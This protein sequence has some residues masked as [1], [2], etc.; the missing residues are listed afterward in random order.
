MNLADDPRWLLDE[1]PS[2]AWF[3]AALGLTWTHD[4]FD[5]LLVAHSHYR[6]WRLATGDG[7][8]IARLGASATLEL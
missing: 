6:G 5:R 1:P 7:D 2:T 8:I 4:P 3:T